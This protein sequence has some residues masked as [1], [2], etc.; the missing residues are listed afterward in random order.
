MRLAARVLLSLVLVFLMKGKAPAVAAARGASDNSY[1][2][3]SLKEEDE[4]FQKLPLYPVPSPKIQLE[5]TEEQLQQIKAE[6]PFY[7]P[8]NGTEEPNEEAL[9]YLPPMNWRYDAGFE[10]RTYNLLGPNTN[11]SPAV[12]MVNEL[13]DNDYFLFMFLSISIKW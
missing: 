5:P 12:V 1:F 13:W 9:N 7:T 6:E 2:W 10:M 8:D 11:P 3:M 4:F